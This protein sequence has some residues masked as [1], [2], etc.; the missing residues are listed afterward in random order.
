M[1][2]ESAYKTLFFQ[3]KTSEFSQKCSAWPKAPS[4]LPLSC[5]LPSP[6]RRSTLSAPENK[7]KWP[8]LP[9]QGE[10]SP[11]TPASSLQPPLSTLHSPFSSL[12][13][14]CLTSFRKTTFQAVNQIIFKSSQ[15]ERFSRYQVSSSTFFSIAISSRPLICAHPVIP[16]VKT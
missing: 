15:N 1:I 5:R 13:P 16:G 9:R 14:Q 12:P 3:A 11:K 8:T 10:T 6:K 2:H 4:T 7:S